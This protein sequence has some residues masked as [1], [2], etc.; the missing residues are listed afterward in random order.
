MSIEA[1]ASAHQTHAQA[2]VSTQANASPA[3]SARALL[4]TRPDL[5]EQPFGKLVEMFAK[6][7]TIPA[8]E[9]D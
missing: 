9:H 4:E 8:E 2:N 5:A 6:G 3:K 7:E 1:V